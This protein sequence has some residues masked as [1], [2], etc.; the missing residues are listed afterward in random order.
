MG[1]SAGVLSPGSHESYV[2]EG[3]ESPYEHYSDSESE[4]GESSRTS[5][6]GE[7]GVVDVESGEREPEIERERREREREG[8]R[9]SDRLV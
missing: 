5:G 4:A 8:E 6:V 3:A 7:S 2:D 9:E 1:P